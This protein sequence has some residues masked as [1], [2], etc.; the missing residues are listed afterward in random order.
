MAP[1]KL[2]HLPPLV[3]FYSIHKKLTKLIL[4]ASASTDFEEISFRQSHL[5]Y[6]Q[7]LS[8]GF[9]WIIITGSL[10]VITP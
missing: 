1:E 2:W 8:H 3:R 5:G 7:P 4:Y 10:Q 6:Y 9:W